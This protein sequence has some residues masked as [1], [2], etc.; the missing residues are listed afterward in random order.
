VFIGA[1]P[2]APAR[3]VETPLVEWTKQFG[4][5]NQKDEATSLA[6]DSLGHVYVA[7]TTYG[8]LAPGGGGRSDLFVTK[9]APN[10]DQVWA[11]QAGSGSHDF[12]WS[13][14]SDSNGSIYLAGQLAGPFGRDDAVVIKY[15]DDGSLVWSRELSTSQNDIA[16]S[17]AADSLGNVFVAGETEGPLGGAYQGYW[18][19]YL[20]RYDASGNLSWIK[21]L[22]TTVSDASYG[23]F[24]DGSGNV[25]VI[26]DTGGAL[27]GDVIG[28]GDAF[29]MKYDS[30]GNLLWSK[31][32]GT[33][34]WDRGLSVAA[35]GAGA[36]YICGQ[37]MSP[38]T[39]G[40]GSNWDAYLAR[41]DVDGDL[42]WNASIATASDDECRSVAVDTSG[43][44]YITG[45][46]MGSLDATSAGGWD[47]FARKYD[48]LGN[49]SLAMQFGT[50]RT[51]E[52]NAIVWDGYGS[53]YLAGY[54][55]GQLVPSVESSADAFL[56]KVTPVPEPLAIMHGCSCVILAGALCLR[57]RRL[58]R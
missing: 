56:M 46:T 16:H 39:S 21:Q 57:R 2:P 19:A 8:T 51:D 42:L 35:D 26:G 37:S 27:G 30:T 50:D 55:E 13:I 34:R 48:A 14:S 47:V 49:L 6:V 17:V 10:G 53:F 32:F 41:F 15:G 12:G 7:G 28:D 1:A 3:A 43:N 24:A 5:T 25:Y 23:V 22:A 52:G 45:R 4:A 58:R 38:N 29:L 31:Q 9:Y 20:G 54:T 36:V 44:A 40:A 33:V 18:D 11:R